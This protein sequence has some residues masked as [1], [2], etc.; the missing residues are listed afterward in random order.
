[1]KVETNPLSPCRLRVVVNADAEETRDDYEAVVRQYLSRGRIPGFRAGKAPRDIVLRA[2]RPHIDQ[3]VR[4]RLVGKLYRKAVEQEKIDVVNF[5]DVGDI[6]FAPETGITFA[7]TVDVAPEFPLP[8]YDGIPVK[9]E[10]ATVAPEKVDEQLARMRDGAAK[11]EDA[12]EGDTV[13]EGDLVSIDFSATSDGKPLFEGNDERGLGNGTGR[14]FQADSSTDPY[15]PGL[16]AGLQGMAVGETRDIAVTFPG[17]YPLETLRGKAASYSV[18]VKVIRKRHPADDAA[19]LEQYDAESLD[20]LRERVA[21][22]MQA[23]AERYEADRRR[24]V[25]IDYLLANADF[26]VPQSVVESETNRMLNEMLQ[27]A[28]S[29]GL[30]RD[31]IES[32]RDDILGSASAGARN[33]VKLHYVV[34]AIAKAESVSVS[35][36]DLETRIREMAVR[37]QMDAA[38]LRGILEKR[39]AIGSIREEIRADKV[40][41]LLLGK[42]KIS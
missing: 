30:Q 23:A 11:Y 1:M 21:K 40:F 14:W 8:K 35:D 7:M 25:V 20:A 34:D 18:T 31:E 29:R 2:Y 13:A 5:V 9:A 33:R 4:Q 38:Q 10:D 41:D 28:A 19:F 16:A 24:K 17:E 12:K 22:D 37:Y 26:D 15:I 36:E 39:E 42:A 27:N 3:D 32:H 6:S